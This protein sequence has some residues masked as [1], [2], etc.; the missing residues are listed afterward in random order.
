MV[1]VVEGVSQ[2]NTLE[3]ND[4]M[5]TNLSQENETLKQHVGLVTWHS[6]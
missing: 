3:M 4:G 5:K 2:N 6:S 1:D